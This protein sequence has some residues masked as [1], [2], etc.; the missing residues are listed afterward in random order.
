MIRQANTSDAHALL[1]LAQATGL[2]EA[3]ELDELGAMMHGHFD[4]DQPGDDTWLVDEED[5]F[6]ALAYFA[7]ERMTSG[8]WNL[9]LIAVHPDAQRSG[10][11]RAMLNAVEKVLR[12][13]DARVLLVETMGIDAFDSVRAFYRDM[14]FA[15]EA[16][17]RDF[18]QQGQDKV[19]YWKSLA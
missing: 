3:G 19:V 13:K 11:G 14:G 10:R 18:Y 5:G 6:K 4:P 1:Q 7:P 15:E 17:I 2:F 9:Y 16:R 8:T 12:E